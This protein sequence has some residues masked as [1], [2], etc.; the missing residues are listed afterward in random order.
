MAFKVASSFKGKAKHDTSSED[1]DDK[2]SLF[3]KRFSKF[4]VKKG[5]CARRK[6]S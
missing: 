3:V 6:K 4:M 1:D 5:Y 2:M